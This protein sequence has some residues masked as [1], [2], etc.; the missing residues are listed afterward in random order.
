M[1]GVKM[2]SVTLVYTGHCVGLPSNDS[3]NAVRNRVIAFSSV[4][5]SLA[6]SR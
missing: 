6:G 2:P 4:G 5:N 3:L 1:P